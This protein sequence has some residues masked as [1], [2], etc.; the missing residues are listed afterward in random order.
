M[1]TYCITF[2]EDDNSGEYSYK[3]RWEADL[4]FAELRSEGCKFARLVKWERNEPKEMDR[5]AVSIVSSIDWTQVTIDHVR[6]ACDHHDAGARPKRPAQN[7]F[8]LLDGNRYPAKFIRG[9]AYKVATGVELDPSND[10]AGGMETVRFFS[11]LGLTTEHNGQIHGQSSSVP[12]AI[13]PRSTPKSVATPRRLSPQKHSLFNLLEGRYGLVEVEKSF[14]W[15]VVPNLLQMSGITLNIFNALQAH[16]GYSAFITPGFELKCDFVLPNERL[17]IEYDERQ[18]FT[19]PRAISLDQYP[20]GLQVGFD[21]EVWASECQR[22]QA[23]DPLPPHRDEQRAFYD[24][25]RDILA[26]ENGYTVVRFRDGDHDWTATTAGKILDDF[27]SRS[28]SRTGKVMSMPSSSD[29]EIL[30]RYMRRSKSDWYWEE[31]VEDI[32]QSSNRSLI[33]PIGDTIRQIAGKRWRE[34]QFSEVEIDRIISIIRSEAERIGEVKPPP[35]LVP[36]ETSIT[37][38]VLGRL[39]SEPPIR[40]L[41]LVSRNY[42]L[43]GNDGLFGFAEDYERIAR[44]CDA[45][46][47]DTILFSL[48]SWDGRSPVAR[49]H[50]T[51]FGKLSNVRRLVL[52]AGDLE[53]H[54]GQPAPE[55]VGIEVW[56]NDGGE[57]IVFRQRFANAP[58]AGKARQYIDEVPCRTIGSAMLVVCGESSVTPTGNLGMLTAFARFGIQVVLNPVHTYMRPRGSNDYHR[59]RLAAFSEAGRIA[60]SVWNQGRYRTEPC[61]WLLFFDGSEKT[62]AEL[63][64]PV[65]GRPDVRIGIVEILHS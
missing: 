46:G 3:T 14:P 31:P 28:S 17:I 62:V 37:D 23:V 22:V 61:P 6:T 39:H 7:T 20:P 10:Y 65:T 29:K 13:P 2:T 42:K 40:K 52:E 12:I 44:R 51:L 45:E 32:L 55:D 56:L 8:L 30:L 11:S 50:D 4:K 64:N 59:K 54:S 60:V 16:R 34:V 58:D 49:A 5:F 33:N 21:I 63:T 9:L 43:R 15:L 38:D 57:P 41:A 19:E 48:Y 26:T 18:H 25:L 47:C 36:Q 53:A 24:S 1:A 35:N 27:V